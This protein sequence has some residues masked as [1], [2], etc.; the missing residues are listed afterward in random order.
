M[1]RV[2]RAKRVVKLVG[3]WAD[4]LIRAG[5]VDGRVVLVLDKSP[6]G[7][8]RCGVVCNADKLNPRL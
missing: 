8:G 5:G 2:R 6:I 3:V 7:R 4:E 1:S